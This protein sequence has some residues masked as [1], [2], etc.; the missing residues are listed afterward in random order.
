MA[1]PVRTT[2]QTTLGETFQPPSGRRNWAPRLSRI[3]IR[4]PVPSVFPFSAATDCPWEK[5][6]EAA[7]HTMKSINLA[8]FRNAP[9]LY[10]A[11]CPAFVSSGVLNFAAP[12]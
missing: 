5:A 7:R 12:A 3:S 2:K 1:H 11:F 10:H 6:A 4:S 8:A 9:T